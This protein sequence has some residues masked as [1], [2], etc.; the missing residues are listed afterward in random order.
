MLAIFDDTDQAGALGYHDLTVNGMP[1]AK[2]FAESDI[3]N[4]LSWTVTASHELLEMLGDPDIDLTV[5]VQ[6]SNTSGVLYTYEVC[7]A[8]ESDSFGYDVNGILV[9]DFV[10]PAW[11]ESFR[12]P[13]SVQFDQQNRISKPFEILQD[14]YIGTFNVAAGSG[15]Q[16]TTLKG[17]S[18][19]R[20][21]SRH[22]RRKKP[23]TCGRGV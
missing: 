22:E 17:V 11:F 18:K 12:G 10:F 23:R 19:I 4:G 15:W 9:S 8:C 1:L 16:Q 21:D 7:D 5:F 14:G 20:V 2:V 3:K 6:S 13:G